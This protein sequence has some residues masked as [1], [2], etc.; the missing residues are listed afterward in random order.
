MPT[1]YETETA[2]FGRR[3]QRLAGHVNAI[4]RTVP[5]RHGPED[6]AAAVLEAGARDWA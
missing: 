4:S 6:G 3:T 1:H 5:A 2:R